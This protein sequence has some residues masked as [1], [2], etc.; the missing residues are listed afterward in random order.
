MRLCGI[1]KITSPSGKIYIGQSVHIAKRIKYYKIASCKGQQK[2]YASILKYGWF[3]HE[4]QVLHIC[5]ESQLNELEEHYIKVFDSFDTKHGLNLDS[6]GNVKKQSE[7]TKRKRSASL[8]GRVFTDEWKRKIGEKSKGRMIGYKHSETTKEKMR[9]NTPP[10][11]RGIPH[12]MKGKGYSKEE[13]RLRHNLANKKLRARKK[14]EKNKITS[15][16]TETSTDGFQ[17]LDK[18]S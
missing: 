12:Q 7:E 14:N 5:D 2:L 16:F 15:L 11:K 18:G 9:L 13:A 6:G 10:R 1:Y 3:N 17:C 8:K 4:F